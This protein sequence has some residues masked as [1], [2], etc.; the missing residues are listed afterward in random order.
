MRRGTLLNLALC[1]EATA[2]L[3]TAWGEFR[4]VEDRPRAAQPPQIERAEFARN[5][6]EGIHQRLPRVKVHL[7][8]RTVSIAIDGRAAPVEL[9]EIGVPVDLGEHEIVAASPGKRPWEARVRIGREGESADVNVPALAFKS[10]EPAP[11][12]GEHQGGRRRLG[13]VIGGGGVASL[14]VGAV[15]GLLTASKVGAS[16]C[17]AP[18]L[19]ATGARAAYGAALT[20]A[21][22]ANV[23]IGVGLVAVAVGVIVVLTAKDPTT[24]AHATFVVRS[25]AGGT[26]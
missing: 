18:C 6:A 13:F 19:D 20:D 8:D 22:V 4:A 21:N 1:H 12:P 26:F 17:P 10:S 5:H 11:V 3:S 14:G 24:A 23:A 15:F 7:V 16:R 25:L 2:K 9:L